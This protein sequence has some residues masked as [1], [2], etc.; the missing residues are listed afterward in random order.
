M[1]GWNT[2]KY[3]GRRV[4]SPLPFKIFATKVQQIKFNNIKH[5]IHM[6][7]KI[8]LNYMLFWV[9]KQVFKSQ[10]LTSSFSLSHTTTITII[11]IIT[12]PIHTN[13]LMRTLGSSSAYILN[14]THGTP[15]DFGD[16]LGQGSPGQT[17][18]I[19]LPWGSPEHNLELWGSP[20]HSWFLKV[21][22][23]HLSTIGGG[24]SKILQHKECLLL[25]F[26]QGITTHQFLHTVLSLKYMTRPFWRL[27]LVGLLHEGTCHILVH[28]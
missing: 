15:L 18:H 12:F 21:T 3:L 23:I 25:S 8:I 24:R 13:L 27:G 20:R 5:I 10:W 7:N 1:F 6:F 26:C 28:L 9:S 19:L 14:H 22:R 4:P 11:I 2:Y 16:T 17:R